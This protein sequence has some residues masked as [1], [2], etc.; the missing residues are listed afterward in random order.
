MGLHIALF[1]ALS[2]HILFC[3]IYGGG[4]DK[5]L[6][7]V[8]LITQIVIYVDLLLLVLFLIILMAV[9][10]RPLRSTPL[11][12]LA[13]VHSTEPQTTARL[14]GAGQQR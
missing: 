8:F 11:Q 6:S 2:F 1:L 12:F 7:P 5:P 4:F 10:S 3:G 13:A 9:D 14:P